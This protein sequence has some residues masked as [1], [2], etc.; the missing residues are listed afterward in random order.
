[1]SDKNHAALMR[2]IGGSI[3]H[4]EPGKSVAVKGKNK[5]AFDKLCNDL[6]NATGGTMTK[7]LPAADHA[8]L[9]NDRT[10]DFDPAQVIRDL[11]SGP[12]IPK[13]DMVKSIAAVMQKA[14]DNLGVANPLAKS[15]APMGTSSLKA[16]YNSDSATMVGGDSLREQSLVK[17]RVYGTVVPSAP[18]KKLTKTQ[19]E[20]ASEAALA[21]GVLTAV[22]TKRVSTC[23]SMDVQIDSALLAKLAG[24]GSASK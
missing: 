10:N 17:T 9:D 11:K 23:L 8:G 24:I 5:G 3:A 16:T 7:A 12:T 1:M 6:S 18:V 22:E 13:I 21:A 19:I 20:R 15:E 2:K 4:R 14:Y